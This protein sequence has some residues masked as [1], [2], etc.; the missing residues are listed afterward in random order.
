MDIIVAHT[1]RYRPR[2]IHR[3]I[4]DRDLPGPGVPGVGM[5]EDDPEDSGVVP[6]CSEVVGASVGQ[7]P[8]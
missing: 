3:L 8:Q 2:S 6:V 1:D 7:R 5:W 4:R